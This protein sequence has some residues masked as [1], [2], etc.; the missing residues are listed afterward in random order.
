VTALPEP[1]RGRIPELDG[2]RGLAILLVLIWHY[3]MCEVRPP[4]LFRFLNLTWSG[5]E[6][7]FVLSGFL[8]GGILLDHRES[9]SYFR[10]FYARRACRILPLYYAWLVLFAI[11]LP[12]RHRLPL[13]SASD[14]IFNAPLPFWS[15]FTFTQNFLQAKTELWGPNWVAVTWSLAIEEQFYLFLPLV[16]RF[17]PR[18]ALPFVLAPL[19]VAAPIAR[20]IL[21]VP[22]NDALAS[23]VLPAGKMDAL[24]LGVLCA[25]LM[26][27]AKLAERLP[28]TLP[29]LRIVLFSCAG[30][31]FL[32]TY[33]AETR[34]TRVLSESM[35]ALAYA[36]LLLLVLNAPASPFAQMA[37]WRWLRALGIIAYGTYIIHQTVSGFVFGVARG[38]WPY[39]AQRSDLL[40]VALSLVLTLAIAAASWRWFE[41]PIVRW[42]RRWNYEI[43]G[44]STPRSRATSIAS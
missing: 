25:W 3:V 31:A 18:R 34:L 24:L 35:L 12:I 17:V 1:D 33:I 16:I 6:L 44:R 29:A 27:N 28:R 32:T 4:L 10:V 40:L 41:K 23:Y 22:R 2:I 14:W 42:S 5:V 26:R 36:S 37:R 7:F 21:Y 20:A 38:H 43:I 13:G 11:V 30:F 15:Y 39:I 19:I 8:I 9:P